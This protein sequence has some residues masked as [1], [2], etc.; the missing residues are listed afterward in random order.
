MLTILSKFWDMV[1]HIGI[2]Q[3]EYSEARRI[4]LTNQMAFVLI[5]MS[6]GY[7]VLS[8]IHDFNRLMPTVLINLCAAFCYPLVHLSNH[9]KQ[10]NLEKILI[11][12][13]P[14][15]QIISVV[16]L[17]STSSG[18]QLYFF[19]TVPAIFII[20]SE[21][22]WQFFFLVGVIFAFLLVQITFIPESSIIQD[23]KIYLDALYLSALVIVLLLLCL[24]QVL[25]NKEIDRVERLLKNEHQ[26]SNQ[27]LLNIL[28]K[29]IAERLKIKT[30]IIADKY[31]EASVLFADLVGFTE[32]SSSM[33]PSKLVGIIDDIFSRF[34]SIV[35]KFS[36]EKIKTIGDSYMIA[37]GVPIENDNH[38]ELIAKAA[39]EM[40][41]AIKDFNQENNENIDIRIGIHSGPLIAGVIGNK[42]ISYDIW[43]DTVN[44][45]SRMESHSENGKI[46]ISEAT[47]HFIKGKFQIE[48]RGEIDIKGKGIMK[49]YYLLDNER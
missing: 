16:Y 23:D 6:W 15:V 46:Q 29:S 28:P 22:R 4:V 38:A 20:F 12:F 11:L 2:E 33:L 13:I 44:I 17:L 49:T 3:Q 24:F 10:H 32:I 1:S 45:A 34:D 14:F 27:L 5:L 26:K 21:K 36:L 30:E 48:K 41:S 31:A 18:I 8:I 40:Q 35:D 7:I 37:G 39:L 9:F 19:L 25:F 47:Y 43:G 42:K